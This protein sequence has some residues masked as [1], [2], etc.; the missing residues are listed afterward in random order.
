MHVSVVIAVGTSCG[1][2][3]VFDEQQTLRWCHETEKERSSVS[4]LCFNG[5]CSR[6]LAGFACGV[7][8]MFDANDGKLLRT[9]T[10]VHTPSTAVLH[11]KVID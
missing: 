3:F 9:M 10:N 8:L 2:V 6:L 11:V 7:I 1:L 4:A 5:D